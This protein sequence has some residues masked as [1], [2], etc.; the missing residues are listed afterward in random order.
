MRSSESVQSLSQRYPVQKV[1]FSGE[2]LSRSRSCWPTVHDP[3]KKKCCPS[4]ENK[5]ILDLE[6][7]QILFG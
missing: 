3:T 7:L 1:R 5:L 6:L 4:F 2:V